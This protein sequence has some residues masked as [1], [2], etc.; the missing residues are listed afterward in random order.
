MYRKDMIP[1]IHEADLRVV[2]TLGLV[3]IAISIFFAT[4]FYK[5]NNFIF[6]RE[7]ALASR[8]SGRRD[9]A[10]DQPIFQFGDPD[11][12]SRQPGTRDI[13]EHVGSSYR[14]YEGQFLQ[15]YRR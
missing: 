3:V 14:D 6:L 1:Q 9:S 11:P 15:G 8:Q 12:Q 2:K 5:F 7:D 10:A 4:L 13:R